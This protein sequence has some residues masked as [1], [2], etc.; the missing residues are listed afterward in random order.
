MIFM[1]YWT[2]AK[3]L[4][5][6]FDSANRKNLR[7]FI[8]AADD[9][10]PNSHVYAVAQGQSAADDLT[11]EVE[12][13]NGG[14]EKK[15]NYYFVNEDDLSVQAGPDS[16]ATPLARVKTCAIFHKLTAGKGVPHTFVG[17]LRQ[18][19]ALPRVVVSLF[20]VTL[21]DM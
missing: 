4:E 18:W 17:F 20:L 5:D 15:S 14:I 1:T 7:H 2:W 12:S 3:G 10:D 16:E 21:Y 11:E 19:P 8:R 6:G 13:S 9:Q